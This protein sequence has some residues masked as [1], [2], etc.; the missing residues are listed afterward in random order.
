MNAIDKFIYQFD[1]VARLLVVVSYFINLY[2]YQSDSCILLNLFICILMQTSIMSFHTITF[3]PAFANKVLYLNLTLTVQQKF[4][5]FMKILMQDDFSYFL[6]QT[7]KFHQII[8]N[9]CFQQLEIEDVKKYFNQITS[10][11]FFRRFFSAIKIFILL[12][13]NIATDDSLNRFL[14]GVILIWNGVSF[15]YVNNSYYQICILYSK[16]RALHIIAN[17]IELSFQ[18]C[19]S[20]LFC[21][22]IL[23]VKSVIFVACILYFLSLISVKEQVQSTEIVDP[24]TIS[25][26]EQIFFGCK[27][28][29]LLPIIQKDINQID[30]IYFNKF[31]RINQVLF[32]I[33]YF[34]NLGF[35]F[36]TDSTLFQEYYVLEIQLGIFVLNSFIA[37]L[38][39]YLIQFKKQSYVNQLTFVDKESISILSNMNKQIVNLITYN[40]SDFELDQK[41]IEIIAQ[42]M[43]ENKQYIQIIFKESLILIN[44]YGN[45]Q[46][47]IQDYKYLTLSQQ[48][49]QEVVHTNKNQSLNV[50]LN[51]SIM[52]DHKKVVKF[53][54]QQLK[55]M[56]NKEE[57][58]SINKKSQVIENLL[59]FKNYQSIE[60][61]LQKYNKESFVCFVKAFNKQI[62]PYLYN[63][64]TSLIYDLFDD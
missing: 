48:I 44:Q 1:S 55:N 34:I 30:M 38:K 3:S 36:F 14:L 52:K 54:F 50:Q 21:F 25:L 58:I 60:K 7:K 56:V 51:K 10:W 42:V 47:E 39:S 59:S 12:D 6:N 62:S 24:R 23:E 40:L 16:Q 26:I 63:N 53:N 9:Q 29:L 49:Y 5:V 35:L 28:S 15:I 22:Y 18:F 45:F 41:N 57:L 20:I 61:I 19:Q 32:Y 31:N 33:Y 2:Y 4:K 13:L 64:P 43:R 27:V 37:I 8:K 17:I 46:I 11:F